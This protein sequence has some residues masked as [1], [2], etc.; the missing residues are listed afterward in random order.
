MRP[1]PRRRQA[2]KNPARAIRRFTTAQPGSATAAR[3]GYGSDVPLVLIA[4]AASKKRAIRAAAC[5]LRR[6]AHALDGSARGPRLWSRPLRPRR[7]W[8]ERDGR[9]RDLHAPLLRC[10][11]V[12]RARLSDRVH[13]RR[14]RDAV[15][16]RVDV[17]G[18]LRF[19]CVRA[20]LRPRLGLRARV[21]PVEPVYRPWRGPRMD[22]LPRRRLL[23]L[24]RSCTTR[25]ASTRLRT[26]SGR[27]PVAARSARRCACAG[28]GGTRARP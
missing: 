10:M 13:V 14:L 12:H 9:R 27:P 17:H 3:R 6:P 11:H 23:A 19:G 18:L 16:G 25:V 21:R 26:W 20:R 4:A 7:G 5:S 22:R 8:L 28:T 15:P 24:S 1:H 2:P